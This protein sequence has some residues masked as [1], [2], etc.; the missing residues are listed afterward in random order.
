VPPVNAVLG[1]VVVDGGLVCG[2]LPEPTNVSSSI[3]DLRMKCSIR[4]AP[5]CF[6]IFV[7][8]RQC[9]VL[10]LVS[11][12]LHRCTVWRN[13]RWTVEKKV[14][15]KR[16]SSLTILTRHQH[17]P[18]PKTPRSTHEGGGRGR[19]QGGSHE[20]NR[21]FTRC[22]VREDRRRCEW[23]RRGE[24]R[25]VIS[26]GTTMPGATMCAL[27]RDPSDWTYAGEWKPP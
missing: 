23:V 13:S 24:L 22:R 25:W 16:I 19:E 5:A 9:P 7:G 1:L 17:A 20:L 11:R 27:H 8:S 3:I 12:I 18:F 15:Q 6:A 4:V 26:L 2:D 14:K 10:Y 21:Y